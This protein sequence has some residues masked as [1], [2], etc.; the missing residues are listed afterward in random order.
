M[1]AALLGG[2]TR[3]GAHIQSTHIHIPTAALPTLTSTPDAALPSSSS[4]MSPHECAGCWPGMVLSVP[5]GGELSAC[6]SEVQVQQVGLSLF[7]GGGGGGALMLRERWRC[8]GECRLVSHRGLVPRL[9]PWSQVVLLAFK[10]CLRSKRRLT[11]DRGRRGECRK[12]T[13]CVTRG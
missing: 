8:R 4:T 13:V 11:G 2:E 3:R 1:V 5:G 6:H 7:C 10:V 9:S 12:K